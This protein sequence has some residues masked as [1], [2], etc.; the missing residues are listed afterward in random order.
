MERWIGDLR[1]KPI[2]LGALLV[3]ATLALYGPVTHHEFVWDDSALPGSRILM[4]DGC[5]F[6][7]DDSNPGVYLVTRRN[8]EKGSTFLR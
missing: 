1:P 2:L 7:P 8:Y 3:L 6:G 5:P 4:F